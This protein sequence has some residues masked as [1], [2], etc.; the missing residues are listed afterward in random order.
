[1]ERNRNCTLHST[2]RFLDGRGEEHDAARSTED[3]GGEVRGELGLDD[4]RVAVRA[5]DA[6]PDDADTRTVDLTLGLVDVGDALRGL[7]KGLSAGF[8][9]TAGGRGCGFGVFTAPIEVDRA[10]VGSTE[11]SPT[12]C[13][14]VTVGKSW[15]LKH[16][17]HKAGRI[18][19]P[20]HNFSSLLPSTSASHRPI[21]P[22]H[23]CPS[24][25]PVPEIHT[26]PK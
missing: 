5:R 24:S 10:H 23:P 2:T 12:P 19:L 26:L 25:S 21:S 20:H 7:V 15:M 4:A 18:P 8:G 13:F 3:L 14:L 22:S 11:S 1:M 6:A 17:L 9:R 16:L